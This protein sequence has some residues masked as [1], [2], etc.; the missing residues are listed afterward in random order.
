MPTPPTEQDRLADIEQDHDQY[1]DC[2][3]DIQWL[4]QE[5]KRLLA[6]Q[7]ATY[8]EVRRLRESVFELQETVNSLEEE[9]DD[10]SASSLPC[11]G[12]LAPE[13]EA[14]RAADDQQRGL[15]G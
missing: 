11:S 14:D 12:R 13:H 15:V 4:I 3:V 5:V 9:R 6:L 1:C 2:R 7:D 8:Q 10:I